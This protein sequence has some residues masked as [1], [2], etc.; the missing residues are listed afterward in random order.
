MAVINPVLDNLRIYENQQVQAANQTEDAAISKDGNVISSV[1]ASN[2]ALA[3]NNAALQFLTNIASEETAS[4]ALS[5]ANLPINPNT[6]NLATTMMENGMS[7]DRESL[8]D[9]LRATTAFPEEDITKLSQMQKFGL[10]IDADTI[11]KFDAFKNY[12]NQVSDG[13]RDIISSIPET[14]NNLINSGRTNEGMQLLASVINTFTA[15]TDASGAQSISTNPNEANAETVQVTGNPTKVM[16]NADVQ[17]LGFNGESLIREKQVISEE[18]ILLKGEDINPDT[19][20]LNN[21]AKEES[22]KA[23]QTFEATVRVPGEAAEKVNVEV[24]TKVADAWQVLENTD[25]SAMV[26]MLKQSG[27]AE[28]EAKFLLSEAATE[29]DFLKFTEDLISKGGEVADSLKDL[30]QSDKFGDI[31][32]SQLQAQMLLNPIDIGEKDTVEALYDRLNQQ[33][34]QLTETIEKLHIPEGKLSENLQNMNQNLDFMEQMNQMVQYIQL[35]LKMNGSEATGDLY[36][37]TDKKKLASKEGNVSALLHLDMKNLGPMDVYASITP[38]NNVFTK[39]YLSSD[40]VITLINDN[41]NILNTRLEKRGYTMKSELTDIKNVKGDRP[42]EKDILEGI[43]ENAK[44][45]GKKLIGR[46]SFEC[47]V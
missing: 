30:V 3:N 15:S 47:L 41:I 40:D 10:N 43:K 32:K 2:S 34:R 36:V 35:P 9:M 46:Y 39:F 13:I 37:Y 45:S 25:K 31:L 26:D 20:T 18:R 12:Q 42:E 19:Q 1:N 33:T 17:G 29:Q 38:G 6:I 28:N 5:A 14:Y 44:N 11:E 8:T 7:I 23:M 27:L 22:L 16:D 4:K 21:E 24:N